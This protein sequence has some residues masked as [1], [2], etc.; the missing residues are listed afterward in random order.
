MH[1]IL[2]PEATSGHQAAHLHTYPYPKLC[3]VAAPWL[4]EAERLAIFS[5]MLLLAAVVLQ[6]SFTELPLPVSAR[7]PDGAFK[8]SSSRDR[9]SLLCLQNRQVGKRARWALVSSWC[10]DV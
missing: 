8:C 3:H 6:M 5:C 1:Y 10:P 7:V 9:R 4:A 2:T